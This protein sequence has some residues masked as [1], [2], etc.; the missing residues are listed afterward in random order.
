MNYITASA[1][2]WQEMLAADYDWPVGEAV[3]IIMGRIGL[4]FLGILLRNESRKG[5]QAYVRE[6][7]GD[8][9]SDG[10]IG[11]TTPEG[12]LEVK[13]EEKSHTFIASLAEVRRVAG[14]PQSS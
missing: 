2:P 5:A 14:E 13:Q 8:R 9:R 4:V 1:M 10:A 12:P 11:S 6:E 7:A 3:E